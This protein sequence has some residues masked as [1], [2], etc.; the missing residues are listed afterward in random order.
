MALP[1]NIG[2]VC[3]SVIIELNYRYAFSSVGFTSTERITTIH[4]HTSPWF[5]TDQIAW[6]YCQ[7]PRYRGGKQLALPRTAGLACELL[8]LPELPSPEHYG[9]SD[10]KTGPRTMEN[11]GI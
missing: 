7:R 9:R 3:V 1:F 5:A 6:L 11:M 8:E 10:T 2:N 4:G